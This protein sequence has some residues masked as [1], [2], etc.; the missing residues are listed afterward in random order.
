[1]QLRRAAVGMAAVAL[2]AVIWAIPVAI[3]A[4]LVLLGM[5]TLRRPRG[6]APV[7]IP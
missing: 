4:V 3:R 6:P 1:M 7:E 5:R 2:V